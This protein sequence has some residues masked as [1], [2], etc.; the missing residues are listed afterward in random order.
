MDQS[1]D[2]WGKSIGQIKKH[3]LQKALNSLGDVEEGNEKTEAI[4]QG[5][6]WAVSTVLGAFD[7]LG[8]LDSAGIGTEVKVGRVVEMCPLEL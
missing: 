7:E 4:V 2:W 3:H 5:V 8:K 6:T 1:S